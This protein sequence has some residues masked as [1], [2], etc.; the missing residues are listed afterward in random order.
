MSVEDTWAKTVEP[1]SMLE[2]ARDTSVDTETDVLVWPAHELLLMVA[3]DSTSASACE[4]TASTNC[5]HA[6]PDIETATATIG[7][8]V[9]A[10]EGTC[11]GLDVV[12]LGV[13]AAVGS[14]QPVPDAIA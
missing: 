12:G 2:R 7:V 8:R 11:D 9:G 3:F 14:S 13:G 1:S 4:N 5:E 6:N 10:G